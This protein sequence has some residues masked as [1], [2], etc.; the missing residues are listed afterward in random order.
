MASDDKNHTTTYVYDLNNSLLSKTR[1]EEGI[2]AIT[3]FT[4]DRNGNQ[5]TQVNNSVQQ[6]H[7]FDAFNRLVVVGRD[8]PG[9]PSI[10]ATYTYRTDGLRH[11]K[12][13]NGVTTTRLW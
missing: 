10:N 7:T 5:L 11:S 2:P 4:Y 1:T 6:I 3:T 12:T 13:V 9:A 8:N